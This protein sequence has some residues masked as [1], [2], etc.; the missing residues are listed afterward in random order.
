MK[1]LPDYLI[2]GNIR[3]GTT[4]TYFMMLQHPQIVPAIKKELYFFNHFG[5]DDLWEKG[6][7]W[8]IS[9][10][11]DC[12]KG[13]I[14]GEA[15][16][17]YMWNYNK[18]A[19]R[20]KQICPNTKFIIILRNPIDKIYSHFLLYVRAYLRNKRKP[21]TTS[22]DKI[23]ED[24]FNKK[25]TLIA[26]MGQRILDRTTYVNILK[27]WLKYFPREQFLILKSEDMFQNPN[28]V[29]NQIFTFLG[30][31]PFTI[32]PLHRNKGRR[33][34]MREI[35]KNKLKEYFEP[36]NKELYKLIGKNFNWEGK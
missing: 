5:K 11:G 29:L 4:S 19:P 33:S 36:Y 12:Q 16:P 31:S 3:C 17:G 13:Q 9:Q 35:W 25:N 28:K 20:V 15:T 7:E 24:T 21:V 26:K 23:M 27:G 14:T 30:L 8:Y 10:L 22:F 32:T 2:L 18:V 1:K 6:K 34:P